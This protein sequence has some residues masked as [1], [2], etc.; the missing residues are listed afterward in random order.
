MSKRQQAILFWL[1][2]AACV[3]GYVVNGGSAGR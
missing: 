1:A 2:L 3:V